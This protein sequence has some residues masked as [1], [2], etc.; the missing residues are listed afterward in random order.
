MKIYVIDIPGVPIATRH[1]KHCEIKNID[2]R[3]EVSYM[4]QVFG[5]VRQF[6]EPPYQWYIQRSDV[7]DFI[8]YK[9]ID[10]VVKQVFKE[11][12]KHDNILF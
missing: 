3:Y 11:T 8:V 10:E 5:Y 1:D 4:G 12:Y 6:I 9:T 2:D 7:V